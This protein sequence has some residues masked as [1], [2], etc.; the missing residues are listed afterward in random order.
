MHGNWYYMLIDTKCKLV[1]NIVWYHMYLE[2]H[3]NYNCRSNAIGEGQNV[4]SNTGKTPAVIDKIAA[5][6]E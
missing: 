2:L 5:K 1:P 4:W 6:N 3:G